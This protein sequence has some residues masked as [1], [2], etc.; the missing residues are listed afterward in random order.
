MTKNTKS[1]GIFLIV[2]GIGSW[3]LPIFGLQFKLIYI[4][5]LL[6]GLPQVVSGI[7]FLVVGIILL[8]LGLRNEKQT[9][10]TK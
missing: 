9:L 10:T 2:L 8:L 7:L 1:F 3:I 4:P 6:L 5:S